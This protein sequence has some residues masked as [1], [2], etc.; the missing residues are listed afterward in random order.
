[1]CNSNGGFSWAG[2]DP[3]LE[4]DFPN[5]AVS[6][7]FGKTVGWIFKDGRDFSRE[8]ASDS[9]AFVINEAAARFLGFENPVGEILTW[10]NRN[11]TI[12]GV[13]QDMI[14]E[15]PYEPV[16]ASLWHIDR[17]DNANLVILKLNPEMSSHDAIEKIKVV[18]TKY[19]PASPFEYQFVDEEYA[20]KFSDEERIGKLAT[21]FAVLA[22][23]ISCLG[24]FGLA[25]FVAEQRTKEIG[26]RKVLGASVVNLWGM[27]SKDFIVL[28]SI[29]LVLSMPLAW[30]FMNGWLLKYEYRS[31]ISWWIFVVAGLGALIITL[32]T[33]SFQ[34]IKA[35]LMNPVKSL[36]SE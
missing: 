12:I 36:R 5:N 2:K 10:N 35:A 26:V 15:S 33:V 28:V 18:F 25:S 6:H 27:L 13:I 23:F 32:L 31:T 22:V 9:N 24:I 4:V 17:Y 29:S 34:A 7:E 21:A 3:A 11:Y 19:N 30:Y 16:R 20:R 1:V 8:F 14:I